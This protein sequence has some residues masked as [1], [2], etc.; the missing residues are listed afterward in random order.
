MTRLADFDVGRTIY[1]AAVY[2][3]DGNN[4]VAKRG[5]STYTTS[6]RE[7]EGCAQEALDGRQPEH[8]GGFWY[9]TIR[10]GQVVDP[11]GDDSPHDNAFEADAD[12][13]RTLLA[14]D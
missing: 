4:P 3:H 10:R 13:S 6:E 5:L 7:A 8:K 11:I 12:W 2:Y 1:E 9:A 14:D